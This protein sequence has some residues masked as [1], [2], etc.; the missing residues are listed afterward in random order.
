MLR[1]LALLLSLTL[2][3]APAPAQDRPAVERQFRI[4]LEATVWPLARGRGVSRTTFDVALAGVALDWDLPGLAPPGASAPDATQTQAEFRSPG[5][6]FDPDGLA[7]AAATGH[8]LRAPHAATL[9]AVERETGVPGRILLAV[10]GRESAFGRAAIPEDAFS[11]L[12][13]RSFMGPQ[14]DQTTDELVAALGI[15]EAGLADPREMRSSWAGALGQPQFLPS[16]V[17]AY[18]TD[19]DGDGRADI[20]GSVDDTLASIGA[21]L[22]G[23]GW[24]RGHDWGF[25]VTVPASVS[26]AL[27]GPDQGRPIAAWEAMGIARASDRPFP[28]V[29][30]EVEGFLVMPAGRHGPAFVVTP[31][32]YVLKD[33]N[34][35]DLYALWVGHLGDR[36]EFGAGG[37]AAPWE[38][39]GDL[40]RADIAA[41]QQALEAMGHDTGGADGLLG[42]R[43]RRA[44]GRW[45]EATGREATCF[46][47]PGMVVTLAP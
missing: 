4:W 28:A 12:A 35:S 40:D 14:P 7:A 36:I 20:W 44:I 24:L 17:L 11:V 21:F 18:A 10:W 16:S 19:G 27:E 45:Q 26:C 31:N 23:H 25:E 15:V 47:E 3:A 5:R 34:T 32:F 2:L 46:P 33:Y 37:F 8:E 13:T 29:E 6:Y 42:F 30:R 43:T 38:D 1:P 9:A 22:A 39:V 41:I